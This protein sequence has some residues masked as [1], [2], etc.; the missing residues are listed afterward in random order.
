[1]EGMGDADKEEG[2][3]EGAQGKLLDGVVDDVM[4]PLMQDVVCKYKQSKYYGWDDDE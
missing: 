4:V 3:E 2:G 1:M